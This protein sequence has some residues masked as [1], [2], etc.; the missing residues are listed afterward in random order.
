MNTKKLVICTLVIFVMYVAMD[1][2]WYSFFFPEPYKPK[3]SS[4][5]ETGYVP[6]AFA[7]G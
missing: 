7:I 6:V 3:A 1:L 4:L 5:R 2:V